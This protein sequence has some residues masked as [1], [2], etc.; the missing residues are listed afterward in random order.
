MD[1]K[2][3]GLKQVQGWLFLFAEWML[4]ETRFSPVVRSAKQGY[5][6]I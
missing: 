3:P 4:I 5:S 1:E 2:Q 6:G